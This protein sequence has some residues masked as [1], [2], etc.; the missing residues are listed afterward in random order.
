MRKALLI[1]SIKLNSLPARLVGFW[2]NWA[3]TVVAV[4]GSLLL[5]FINVPPLLPRVPQLY[6]VILGLLFVVHKKKDLI[7]A[8][9][10][11]SAFSFYYLSSPTGIFILDST[12]TNRLI[13]YFAVAPVVVLVVLKLKSRVLALEDQ[14]LQLA[15]K[16]TRQKLE[17]ASLQLEAVFT[18]MVDGITVQSPE[19]RLTYVNTT[20]AVMS[21]F[22]SAA[23]MLAF[24]PEKLEEKYE[25]MDESRNKITF[26]DLPG[27]KAASLKTTEEKVIG[28]KLKPGGKERW[29]Q[30]RS[31]AVLDGKGRLL[32]VI[33]ML[34]DITTEKEARE[35]LE[36][37]AVRE[38][39]LAEAGQILSSSLNYQETLAQIARLA[40][41]KLADWA[42]VDM[43]DGP[44]KIIR[45]AV[46]H[47]DPEKVKWA[48]KIQ[49]EFPFDPKAPTGLA[50]VL[51]TGEP[52]F[53]P[54]VTMD[55]IRAATRDER[56]LRLIEDLGGISAT[57][58]VPLKIQSQT[59]GAISFTNT[60]SGKYYTGEDLEL[61]EE[62]ARRASLAVQNSRLYELARQTADKERQQRIL[63]DTLINNA[64]VGFIFL[65][66]DLK[67]LLIN[68]FAAKI[69]GSPPEA[70]IGKKIFDLYPSYRSQLEPIIK[71]VLE[72]NESVVNLEVTGEIPS[73]PGVKRYWNVNYYPVPD[74]GGQTMG[75]GVTFEEI[76]ERIRSQNEIIFHAFSDPLTLLPN[77][78]RFQ[79][80]V[81]PAL[82][83]ARDAK[84]KL[85]LMFIDMDR[86]KDI[87]DS[88]G[89][90]TGDD[91]I[92]E[93][94]ARIKKALPETDS[95]FRWGGDEFVVLAENA[96]LNYDLERRARD[97]LSALSSEVRLGGHSLHVSA[98]IGIA[99]FPA[100]GQDAASLQ[101]NA[102]TALY[103]AKD[104]GKNQFQFYAPAMNVG[105]A[106]KLKL[107]NELRKALDKNEII[108]HYQ[109]I[110]DVKSKAISSV[111]A[112]I[113]WQHPDQGLLMPEKFVG[114]AEELGIINE[115]GNWTLRA[116][117]ADLVTLEK[118]GFLLS[119]NL[120]VSARQFMDE[121]L[122]ERILGTLRE[123]GLP[124]EALELEITESLA[125]Q[126]LDRSQSIL[127][128]L[129]KA[130]VNITI[131]DFGTGYSSF[132]YLKRFPISSIKIDKAFVRHCITDGQDTSIIKAITSMGK[133]LNLRV[134]AEGVDTEMQLGLLES[135]GADAVQGYYISKPLSLPGLLE[136]LK[137]RQASRN[138]PGAWP[139]GKARKPVPE[140]AAPKNRTDS[141]AAGSR[142]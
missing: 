52:E 11:S 8:L 43:A 139:M 83:K 26:H 69:Y 24:P 120:N 60:E 78:K 1:K 119:A 42:A 30:V 132:N 22:R 25:M 23:E 141:S 116:A 110:L 117:C 142:P 35:K 66:R 58:V 118:E 108:L 98:S 16:D 138:L 71:R 79:E 94:A 5:F 56:V 51:R 129:Q 128:E 77:R 103:R 140:T 97:I 48:Y 4:F 74:P 7:C 137:A 39:F 131:D 61:A 107:E 80:I 31:K 13:A 104:F 123:F 84:S 81:G 54:V 73:E 2:D 21:G 93:A 6:L 95:L 67:Y 121:G 91:I 36:Q 28:F 109:P 106:D 70:H 136:F 33:N 87:N 89:H 134:V 18:N 133:N 20:A 68:K 127:D 124:P 126:N 59:I 27:R 46:A 34:R 10:L 3:A 96:Q 29:S 111:E 19:G 50:K 92:K 75:V 135:L 15:F 64:P 72:K 90:H 57:M 115:L 12:T 113:R 37:K 9:T 47:Q 112:L 63:M 38:K 125:M 105:A 100:D 62:L 130:G 55:L 49:K 53:Y 101:R 102:D 99:V 88:L 17:H 32:M 14:A 86:L 85:G 41:A 65:N 40:V 45:L 122:V 114:L 76:T 44:D 82:E